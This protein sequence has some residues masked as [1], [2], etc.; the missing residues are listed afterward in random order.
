MPK[1]ELFC[2]IDVEADGPGPI[3]N[4]MLSF[5]VA[6]LTEDK[7]LISVFARNLALR[8][9]CEPDAETIA[10]WNSTPGNASAYARTRESVVS[11]EQ[12]M[13]E[14]IEWIST[15]KARFDVTPLAWPAGYDY[16]WI[17]SYA[18]A[19]GPRTKTAGGT[20]FSKPPM[21]IACLDGKSFALGREP[22]SRYR[23]L[24]K[25]TYPKQWFDDFVHTHVAED[26]A[27]EQGCLLVNA[28]REARGLERIHG[29]T[30]Q[31]HAA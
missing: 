24:S 26:D 2:S 27:I 20:V 8:P 16:V 17:S 15:M 9:E 25:R 19:F 1:P 21:G 18:T 6:G 30:D 4:N 31:R 13:L 3:C 28:L 29:F 5:A 23:E 22:Q 11:P 12:A 7:R 14:L 10:W